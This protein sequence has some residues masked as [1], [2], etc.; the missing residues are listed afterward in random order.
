[1]NYPL[2]LKEMKFR[3]NHRNE[4][5]LKLLIDIA[6][7]RSFGA[8]LHQSPSL[9]A[10]LICPISIVIMMYFMHRDGKLANNKKR[11]KK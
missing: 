1:M 10:F 4:N 8:E 3:F 11:E 5:V 2:Y 9:L 6:F 7:R